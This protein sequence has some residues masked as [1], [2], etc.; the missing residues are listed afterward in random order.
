MRRRGGRANRRDPVVY[1]D[2]LGF[3][4]EEA[5]HVAART[6]RRF[7]EKW[8]EKFDAVVL[9]LEGRDEGAYTGGG[10]V[11]REGV[12]HHEDNK[13]GEEGN[14]G[15]LDAGGIHNS[16]S[17]GA[18]VLRL[19]FPRTPEEADRAER[20]LPEDTGNEHGEAR[21]EERDIVISAGPYAARGGDAKTLGA[22][23]KSPGEETRDAGAS[24]LA[25]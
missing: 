5:A 24:S 9:C 2:A 21:N 19:Y 8:P 17:S 23:Q 18:G 13:R 6:I 4:R 3:P 7:L 12:R 16:S 14:F 20:L 1:Q 10:R 25:R 15:E 22:T 11:V